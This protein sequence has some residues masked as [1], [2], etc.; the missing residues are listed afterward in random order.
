MAFTPRRLMRGASGASTA[1]YQIARSLRFNAADSAYLTRNFTGSG[2]QQKWTW[3]AW[4]K[5]SDLTETFLFGRSG[6]TNDGSYLNIQLAGSAYSQINFS[7]YSGSINVT[8]TQVLR[9]VSAWYHIVFAL[10][11]TQATAADRIKIYVNG[12]QVTAFSSATYPS[13]NDS[14]ILNGQDEHVIGDRRV[15]VSYAFNGYMTEVNFVNAQQ[16]TPSSFG[17][18]NAQTGVWQ[19]KAYSGSYGTNGFYLNFS[20]NSNTTAVTLGKDYSGNG[21]NWTPNN[22]SVTAGAGNDSMVD[23]PTPYGV[24]TGVGGTVRGN[25][26]T[27]NPLDKSTAGGVTRNGNLDYAGTTTSWDMIRS[28]FGMSSGKWY[29][30]VSVNSSTY[31]ITG[32]AQASVVLQNNYFNSGF[33]VGYN[34]SNG[35]KYSG[36]GGATGYGASWSASGD[37]CG[38]AFDADAGTITFYKNGTSQGV[39]YTGLTGTYFPTHTLYHTSTATINFGQRPFAYTAPSGFKALC[40]QNLPTPTIGSTSATRA[41]R[42]F[43]L[44]TWVGNNGAQTVTNNIDYTNGGG[45][46][47]FKPRDVTNN[48]FLVNSVLGYTKFLAPNRTDGEDTY[49]FGFT[50]STTGFSFNGGSSSVNQSPYNYIAWQWKAGGS[51]VTNTAGSLTSQVS[52]NPTAGF[53]ILTYTGNAAAEQTIGHGLG[54]VPKLIIVKGRTGGNWPVYHVDTGRNQYTFLNDNAA[55]NTVTGYWGSSGPTTTTFGVIGGGYGNNS[56]TAV[57]FCFAEVE[58]YSKIGSYTGN[59]S[60]NGPFVHCGFRPAF[61][62]I[63]YVGVEAWFLFDVARGTYNPNMPFIQVN[64][65]TAVEYAGDTPDILSNG[66]KLTTTSSS[67]NGSGQLQLFAAFAETPFKY[68]LAR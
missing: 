25:Y 49:D 63:R 18:T 3:S 39:A 2:N 62:L 56:G 1:Q 45:L 67:L 48:H 31:G 30:E 6:G 44:S 58:G 13:L 55:T 60:A 34:A 19:P 43:A 36:T 51:T 29:W 52:A 57:A 66:F 26:C 15:S 12:V 50:P 23:V 8:T 42:N 17:E 7:N 65:Y 53:S 14:L 16:L 35:D 59:G 27:L 28:T 20:D 33:C 4:I 11:T 68:A 47:W 40:T 21:N 32:I 54:A 64:Q 24:D 10:D 46:V 5:R 37:I 9:D 41:N 38:V 61:I 22:F